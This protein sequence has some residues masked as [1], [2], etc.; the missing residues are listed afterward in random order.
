[1]KGII[2]AEDHDLPQLYPLAQ[3]IPKQ[4]LPVFDKPMIYYPLS[5]LMLTGIR[6]ILIV[7]SPRT[8]PALQDTLGTGSQWGIALSYENN[9]PPGGLLNALAAGSR[10][11]GSENVALTRGD[12]ILYGR[13]IFDLM[14]SF[15]DIRQGAAMFAHSVRNP[16]DYAVVELDPE[17][18]PLKIAQGPQPAGPM[19]Y[20]VP[21]LYFYDH[22]ATTWAAQILQSS[23]GCAPV[24]DLNRRYM[25]EGSLRVVIFGRGIAWMDADSPESLLQAANFVQVIEERQGFMISCPEEIAYR[26]GWI[27]LGQ[28]QRLAEEAQGNQYG[29]YL[30]RLLEDAA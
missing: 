2:L 6:E 18:R 29:A 15:T 13:D 7:G 4:L 23:S 3:R 1:M 12:H 24:S 30:R 9:L 14:I 11:A 16:G 19:T 27:T 28:L 10:F 17:D 21:D 26:Q 20:A 25:D 22:R 8:I 5:T